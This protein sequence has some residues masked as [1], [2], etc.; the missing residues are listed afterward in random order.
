M[1][2]IQKKQVGNTN[3][4]IIQN[5]DKYEV[6]QC[7]KGAPETLVSTAVESFEEAMAL[8]MKKV[9][10][11]VDSDRVPVT[12]YV[13]E[14]FD[15]KQDRVLIVVMN[16]GGVYYVDVGNANLYGTSR[17]EIISKIFSKLSTCG[18]DSDICVDI[19]FHE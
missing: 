15:Y 8:F 19:K 9:N 6:G 11:L 5:G 18:Y 14:S 1:K 3:V 7:E 10:D 16:L 2:I 12:D 17:V 13:F 4:A